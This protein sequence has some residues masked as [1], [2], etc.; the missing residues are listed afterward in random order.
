MMAEDTHSFW[1][2][3][4]SLLSA[5]LHRQRPSCCS[6]GVT[7]CPAA[8]DPREG[9]LWHL[10]GSPSISACRR[11]PSPSCCHDRLLGPGDPGGPDTGGQGREGQSRGW[12]SAICQG[13]RLRA[14]SASS[15][16]PRA[17][18][19][20]WRQLGGGGRFCFVERWSVF[21]ISSPAL[22]P[23]Q[24]PNYAQPRHTTWP[25]AGPM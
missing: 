8:P 19:S 25:Q 9:T 21:F 24:R 5:P 13:P 1:W 23:Q 15:R 11:G 20:L 18:Q 16:P 22:G 2:S 6:P 12:G 4:I 3:L 17:L 14:E 7:P 10:A